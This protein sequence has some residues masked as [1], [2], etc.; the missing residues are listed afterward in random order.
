MLDQT[1]RTEEE[2]TKEET[3]EKDDG[4]RRRIQEKNYHLPAEAEEAEELPPEVVPDEAVDEEVDT[5]A[6]DSWEGP[7]DRKNIYHEQ[8]KLN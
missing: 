3:D 1:G 4:K 6:E 5:R 2:E 7:L 8:V